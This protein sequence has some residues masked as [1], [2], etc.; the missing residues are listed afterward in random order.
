MR[1]VCVCER[2]CIQER[3]KRKKMLFFVFVFQML[4]KVHNLEN[5]VLLLLW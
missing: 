5:K 1:S 2:V 3:L 4:I